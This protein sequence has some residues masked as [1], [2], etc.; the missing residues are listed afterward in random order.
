MVNSGYAWFGWGYQINDKVPFSLYSIMG[1]TNYLCPY[2]DVSFGKSSSTHFLWYPW[3]RVNT[4]DDNPVPWDSVRLF[5]PLLMASFFN[6]EKPGLFARTFR[7]IL[8]IKDITEVQSSL[9]QS[10]GRGT[11]LFCS[12]CVYQ[13]ICV[14]LPR[15]LKLDSSGHTVKWQTHKG[16][17]RCALCSQTPRDSGSTRGLHRSQLDKGLRLRGGRSA[18]S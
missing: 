9:G 12:V 6:S 18:H 17:L 10:L 15:V 1:H 16:N 2:G 3:A 4:S 8:Y 14:Q 11:Q 5:F 7:S 13:S